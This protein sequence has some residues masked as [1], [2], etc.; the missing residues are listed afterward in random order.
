[1]KFLIAL[2]AA[3]L[4][5]LAVET[6]SAADS[7]VPAE[8]MMLAANEVELDVTME[9]LDEDAD[10]AAAIM[11]VIELPSQLMQQ[12]QL[13]HQR[14]QEGLG[15]PHDDDAPGAGAQEQMRNTIMENRREA[16]EAKRQ[17]IDAAGPRQGR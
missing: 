16:E 1:M 15:R 10:S 12:E 8:V 13:R 9:M 6:A 7:P 4:L 11:H 2:L 5:P 17:G 3:L 14:R